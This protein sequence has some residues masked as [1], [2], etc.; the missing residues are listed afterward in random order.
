MGG[1]L[2]DDPERGQFEG[3]NNNDD[4]STDIHDS[5]NAPLLSGNTSG[6]VKSG[7]AIIRSR[8]DTSI[9]MSSNLQNENRTLNMELYKACTSGNYE[10]VRKLLQK[11][12]KSMPKN[13]T[14]NTSPVYITCRNGFH[15]I[16]DLLLG[17]LEENDCLIPALEFVDK[18]GNSLFHIIMKSISKT[19]AKLDKSE[20]V[21]YKK[22]LVNFLKY[23][24]CEKYD[25]CIFIKEKEHNLLLD[26]CEEGINELVVRLLK[27]GADP[28]KYFKAR[29]RNFSTHIAGSNGYI[30]IF[31]RLVC[32]LEELNKLQNGL[33]LKDKSG[34][35]VLHAIVKGLEK[36]CKSA[37]KNKEEKNDD[38]I[39][40]FVE[41]MRVLLP[42]YKDYVDIDGV[43]NAGNTALHTAALLQRFHSESR[44]IEILWVHEASSD[45]KN[46][47]GH[48]AIIDNHS[49]IS[50][51]EETKS[52][53]KGLRIKTDSLKRGLTDT[54]YDLHRAEDL[55]NACES[56]SLD[57]VNVY[58]EIA[59]CTMFFKDKAQK[60]AIRVAFSKGYFKIIDLL[61]K[62]MK[63]KK[64]D[65]NQVMAIIKKLSHNIKKKN[66]ALDDDIDYNKCLDI[67]VD[68]NDL[69]TD[70]LYAACEKGDSNIVSKLLNKGVDPTLSAEQNKESCPILVSFKNGYHGI[71]DMLLK[72]AKEIGKLNDVIREDMVNNIII[73]VIDGRNQ[74]KEKH[75]KEKANKKDKKRISNKI[76]N[77]EDMVNYGE[78]FG[79]LLSYLEDF[80]LK[81]KNEILYDV[82]EKGFSDLVRKLLDFNVDPAKICKGKMENYPLIIAARKGHSDILEIILS[83]LDQNKLKHCL[84]Q[85]TE[86]YGHTVLHVIM[87][88]DDENSGT[89]EDY[90][91]CMEI[92]LKKRQYFN[93]DDQDNSY[94]T[95][96][97]YAVRL[98]GDW[99]FAKMLI[100]NGACINV[101]NREGH[102]VINR[103]PVN[104][105]EDILDECIEESKHLNDR[106]NENYE[107]RMDLSIFSHKEGSLDTRSESEFI[108]ALQQ[109]QSHHQLL[110]HPLITTFIHIK[111]QKVKYNWYLNLFINMIFFFLIFFYIFYYGRYLIINGEI[112]KNMENSILPLKIVITILGSFL[113][114]REI[115]Q[116][117]ILKWDYFKTFDNYLEVSIYV[118]TFI[119]LYCGNIHAQHSIGAWLV[120]FST[121]EI[122]L[123]FEKMHLLQM[124]IYISM[125][126]KVTLNFVKLTILLSWMVIAFGVS[127]Y[128]LF[129]ITS[130]NGKQNI[131]VFKNGQTEPEVGNPNITE[132]MGEE[133]EDKF[134]TW[135]GAF[136]KT[137]VMSTG[138]F[139][140]SDLNFDNFPLASKLLFVVFIF[141]IF[142]VSMNLLNGI[143]ISDI[144]IIQNDANKYHIR[145]QIELLYKFD[146]LKHFYRRLGCFNYWKKSQI[147]ECCFPDKV[148]E[149]ILPNRH[150]STLWVRCKGHKDYHSIR[151][152]FLKFQKWFKS[153]LNNIRYCQVTCCT[154]RNE[155]IPNTCKECNQRKILPRC[156]T[157]GKAKNL[158]DECQGKT[159]QIEHK[160]MYRHK[161]VIPQD[162]VIKAKLKKEELETK[163]ENIERKTTENHHNMKLNNINIRISN[164]ERQHRSNVKRLQEMEDN[165]QIFT[166][167]SSKNNS[168]ITAR[169]T[170]I[171]NC[172]ES[173][174]K[175]I[176]RS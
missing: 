13:A 40:N 146:Q 140:Y 134:A 99:K 32:K 114:L 129:H 153:L 161:Y 83:H 85:R 108:T 52:I 29:E 18:Y 25:G 91:K 117:L 172:L 137:L 51:Y 46:K 79:V 21:D 110:Y 8:H 34:H 104:T 60:T 93:I 77:E 150:Y 35:S 69:F 158:C 125:F 135:N 101:K 96:L 14:V 66:E 105:I 10:D 151:F 147:F 38:E 31:K 15:N 72:K 90:K 103:I 128:L 97:H 144:Q 5:S 171:E 26:A 156:P 148:I 63:K 142:L 94:N 36:K 166:D 55:Y 95:A 87:R 78:A 131:Q 143:A 175:H 159:Q 53:V 80:D 174:Q 27:D 106:E 44:P 176:M 121:M 39:A 133:N 49:L 61:I 168:E 11:G 56:G 7:T 98:R 165:I 42:K 123:L 2:D 57:Q 124:A 100:K 75:K 47:K 162:Y 62:N 81:N 111:W 88:R 84:N 50:T 16:L 67:L 116:L 41:C 48:Y 154:E 130:N 136:L 126:K 3:G 157:C 68:H 169:L 30:E 6:K 170:N 145:D 45:I 132:A 120:V 163:E 107:I 164:I 115:I 118:L 112:D 139:D 37:R 89:E 119:M 1:P 113:M 152:Y 155:P 24:N 127:F 65:L 12:A 167:R 19:K 109:S 43:D 9:P 138:E 141:S 17:N 59:D 28:A 58:V 73:F 74:V 86:K 54:S 20:S 160:C 173:I 22:C 149:S 71:A 4:D 122:I 33:Q 76:Q 102:C 82:C 70:V 92:L 64:L 23:I